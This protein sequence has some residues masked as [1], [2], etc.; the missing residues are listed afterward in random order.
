MDLSE[1]RSIVSKVTITSLPVSSSIQAVI[2]AGVRSAG[3]VSPRSH[4]LRGLPIKLQPF[5]RMWDVTKC[6]EDEPI[7]FLNEMLILMILFQ[8]H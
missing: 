5:C 2:G 3:Q 7:L 1:D 4:P 6:E 8:M